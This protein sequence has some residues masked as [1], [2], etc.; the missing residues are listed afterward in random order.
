MKDFLMRRIL[1]LSLSKVHKFVNGNKYN[2][3]TM[4]SNI[5]TALPIADLSRVMVED[6]ETGGTA[7]Q[8]AWNGKYLAISFKD[9]NSVAIFQTTIRK[10]QL[11]VM[12]IGL[13]S[14]LAFEFPTFISWQPNYGENNVLTIA[15]SSGEIQFVPFN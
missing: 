14:K 2:D 12:P 1:N 5:F 10:H 4:V 6:L 9:T 7:Q 11:N 15:W 3:S 13:V 8:L